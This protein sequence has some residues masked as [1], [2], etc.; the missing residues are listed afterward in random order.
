[1][2]ESR[3]AQRHRVLKVGL[4]EFSAGGAIP[5]AVKNLSASGAALEVESAMDIPNRLTLAIPPEPI[6]RQCRVVW[7]NQKRIGVTFS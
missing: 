3:A 6:K 4:I 7:R 5:C 2:V 1:M